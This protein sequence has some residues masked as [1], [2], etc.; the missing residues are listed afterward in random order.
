MG[1]EEKTAV[2]IEVVNI[3]DGWVTLWVTDWAGCKQTV[4]V[5]KGDIVNV[6]GFLEIYDP[7][8]VFEA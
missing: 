5:R 2:K 6:R 8:V 1:A 4:D 7:D 3:R